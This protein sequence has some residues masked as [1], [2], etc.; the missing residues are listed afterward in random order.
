MFQ[1]RMWFWDLAH[2]CFAFKYTRQVIQIERNMHA[3]GPQPYPSHA[4]FNHINLPREPRSTC[5]PPASKFVIVYQHI[6]T[7]VRKGVRGSGRCDGSCDVCCQALRPKTARFG[8]DDTETLQSQTAISRRI[9]AQ[10][11]MTHI[12]ALK[13]STTTREL[14]IGQATQR[15]DF[16]LTI[17]APVAE[18]GMYCLANGSA[19]RNSSFS[20]TERRRS[21]TMH[22]ELTSTNERSF[23]SSRCGF[24]LQTEIVPSIELSVRL[25]TVPASCAGTR[26]I[27]STQRGGYMGQYRV[28]G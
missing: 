6:L 15:F 5:Q 10:Q 23:F 9:A 1:S 17:P 19:Q 28:M 22:A 27:V 20:G 4:R 24:A 3:T 14:M 16:Y 21:S 8:N 26:H 11:D 13:P 7:D 25:K 2:E 18:V 12:I